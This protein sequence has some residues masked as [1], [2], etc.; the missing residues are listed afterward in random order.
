M[1]S[2]ELYLNDFYLTKVTASGLI[3][4]TPTGSTAYNMSAGG[5]IVE[6]EVK[7]LTV[8]PL[9]PHALSFRPLV[10]PFNTKITIKVPKQKYK[11][12]LHG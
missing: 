11:D 10:L 6:T 9:N 4:A 8:T 12:N 5:S 1:F 3:F 2:V 7:A